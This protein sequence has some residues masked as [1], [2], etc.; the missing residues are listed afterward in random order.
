MENKG[1]NL[2]IENEAVEEVVADVDNQQSD[3]SNHNRHHSGS[4]HHSSH[5]H[6]SHHGEHH[7]VL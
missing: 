4:H 1:K 2:N 7:Q 3:S 6:S 5:H